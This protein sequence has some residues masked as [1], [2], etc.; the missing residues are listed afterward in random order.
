MI[1]VTVTENG[2]AKEGARVTIYWESG[3]YSENKTNS[4]G[5][6]SFRNL[7]T[8]N[9]ICVFDTEKVTG[10]ITY[11]DGAQITATT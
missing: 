8:V 4:G 1:T 3:G 6:V 9:R 11:R 7:G 5:Q 2:Y 10:P